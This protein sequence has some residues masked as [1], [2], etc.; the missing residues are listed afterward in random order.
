MT[1]NDKLPDCMMPDGAN[2]CV[3]YQE[4]CVR[5]AKMELLLI[6][7][8]ADLLMRADIDSEGCNVVNL[9]DSIWHRLKK[10]VKDS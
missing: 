9:S 4:L 7:L 10:I 3:G 8:K 2:P 1:N 6:D 5:A